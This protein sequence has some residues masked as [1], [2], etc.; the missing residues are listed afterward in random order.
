MATPPPYAN[1]TGIFTTDDKHQSVTLANYD[2]SARPGQLVIDSA[3]YQLYIGNAEGN[4]NLVTG[5]SGTSPA[6]SNTQVQF[7]DAGSFG[8]TGSLTFDKTANALGIS[9]QTITGNASGLTFSGVMT[10]NGAGLTNLLPGNMAGMPSAQMLTVDPDGNNA[11]AD[12]SDNKPFQTIQAAHDYAAANM[13]STAYVAIKLN[14]GNYA[15]NVTLSR[16]KTAIVGVTDGIIRSSWIAGSIT[17]NMPTSSGTLSSDIFALENVIVTSSSNAIVLAGSERYVFFARNTYVYASGSANALTVTNTGVGGIKVDLLN[18]FLQCD[19][20]GTALSTSN[21][22]YLNINASSLVAN[23]GPALTLTT[24]SGFVT[25][26]RI[27][28]TSGSNVVVNTS[29]FAP[30]SAISFGVCTFESTATNGNGLYLSAGST[31]ALGGCAFNVPTGTGFAVAGAAGSVLIKS[32]N[33]NQIAY[34]TN[35]STQGA[36]TVLPMNYL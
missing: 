33:N 36:V 6:G 28:T 26:S 17:V 25:T 22:Y 13:P 16:A 4:L 29:Q 34:N 15:G 30:G 20:S 18:V 19:G 5:G 12:G 27:T 3:T 8:A 35:G 14:A 9:S 2:G 10:G 32:A 1:I 11:T 24:T 7:N 23:T 21:T 31:L